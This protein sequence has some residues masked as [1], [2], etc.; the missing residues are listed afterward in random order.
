MPYITAQVA[1]SFLAIA[2]SEK[3]SLDPMKLQKLVYFSHG[4]HL[5]FGE[6][7]LCVEYAQ[8]W[9]WGPVFPDLYH[10][11]KVW[12]YRPILKPLRV[13]VTTEYGDGRVEKPTIPRSDTFATS[14]VAR[15]W[16][17]YGPFD[18]VELS[19]MTHEHGGPWQET[20]SKYGDMKHA[21]IPDRL[22]KKYFAAKIPAD[23]ET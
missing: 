10:E 6:G 15:V 4:W 13:F 23:A 16:E 14:L 7:A 19:E 22:I 20:R 9:R 1:N 2:K 12:G 21:V 3:A 11:V 8:A 5:G 18:G 17:V